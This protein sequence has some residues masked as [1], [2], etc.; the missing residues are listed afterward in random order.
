MVSEE[1]LVTLRRA[2]SLQTPDR[3][4]WSGNAKGHAPNKVWCYGFRTKMDVAHDPTVKSGLCTRCRVRGVSHH[5]VHFVSRH[6]FGSVMKKAVRLERRYVVGKKAV[7]KV[8]DEPT[9]R[10]HWSDRTSQ[11]MSNK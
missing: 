4:A 2:E 3:D 5:N 1:M 10:L 8:C 9:L 11:P 6:C 7:C